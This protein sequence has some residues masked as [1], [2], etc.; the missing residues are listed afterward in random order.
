MRCRNKDGQTDDHGEIPRRMT[1]SI[2]AYD[3]VACSF[4]KDMVK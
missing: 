2:T 3:E 4:S 1:G